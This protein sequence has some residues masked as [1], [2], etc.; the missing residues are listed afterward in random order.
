MFYLRGELRSETPNVA[1]KSN[2]PPT[3]NSP[4]LVDNALSGTGSVTAEPLVGRLETNAAVSKLSFKLK[5]TGNKET[6]DTNGP[7]NEVVVTQQP[8]TRYFYC[9]LHD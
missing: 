7:V 9:V 3:S 4:S 6:S 5:D 8:F 1:N 2:A